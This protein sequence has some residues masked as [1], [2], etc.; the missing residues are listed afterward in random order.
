MIEYLAS[1]PAPD[2][3]IRMSPAESD[4][5]LI[6]AIVISGLLTIVALY[7][8]VRTR[9]PLILSCL[10][11][12]VLCVASEPIWDVIGHLHFSEGNH[13]A[14]TMFT[15]LQN[16]IHYPWWA[17][18][19]YV[20]FSGISAY[21]FYWIFSARWTRVTYWWLAV[22][23]QFVMNV[24]VEVIYI[25]IHAYQYYGAEQPLRV[26]GFPLWWIFADIGELL[27][28]ALLCYFVPRYGFRGALT[29]IVI[30]PSAFGAWQLWAGWPV[31]TTINMDISPAWT[32]LAG[33]VTAAISLTT[34]W[35]IFRQLS[36]SNVPGVRAAASGPDAK[37]TPSGRGLVDDRDAAVGK[38][39]G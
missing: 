32:N 34:I 39:P 8:L 10:V 23:G 37:P 21:L 6:Y 3:S 11:G 24:A 13:F 1:A 5:L 29:P 4:G 28:G 25:R 27:A 22:A 20:Q 35:F 19:S 14:F 30:V 26:L 16:P 9:S 31:Y 18:L 38:A 33:V 36:A 7:H 2:P 12:G 17:V 15:Q